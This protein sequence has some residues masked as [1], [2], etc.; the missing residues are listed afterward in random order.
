MLEAILQEIE[1]EDMAMKKTLNVDLEQE[2][3]MK[4]ILLAEDDELIRR[5]VARIIASKGYRVIEAENGAE[6]LTKL[7]EE[8]PALILTD[9][10]MPVMDGF[11]LLETV[12]Q[13]SPQT[14]VIIFSGVGTKPDIITALRAG[15]WDYIMKPIEDINYLLDSIEQVLIQSEMS[16]GYQHTMEKALKKKNEELEKELKERKILENQ[17]MHAKQEWEKTVDSI[18]EPIA[19]VDKN[20]ALIRVNKAMA[21][22]LGAHPSQV[23][24]KECY[25]STNGFN[26]KK[27]AMVDHTAL[28][29]GR[30][31]TGKFI[32]KDGSKVYEVSISPYYDHT[33]RVVIGAVYVARNITER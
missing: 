16:Y 12:A 17:L 19:L 13:E 10:R 8:H 7:R 5:S 14:P 31:L 24:G 32:G 3:E 30:H 9:L 26:N 15:A 11:E 33:D 18:P 20:S 4:T 28:L 23:I 6:A 27:Q 21:K 25:L 29:R 2:E 22:L 1:Q